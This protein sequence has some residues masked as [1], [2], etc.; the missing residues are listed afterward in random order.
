MKTIGIVRRRILFWREIERCASESE[1]LASSFCPSV[2]SG[3][4]PEL[5]QGTGVG[6][7]SGPELHEGPAD[8]AGMRDEPSN[9][10]SA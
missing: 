7:G 1:C 10:M 6:T 3:S 4:G 5:A 2:R 8:G 9:G